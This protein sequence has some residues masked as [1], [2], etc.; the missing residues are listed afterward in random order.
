M[1]LELLCSGWC[2]W[3]VTILRQER[4][5][6]WWGSSGLQANLFVL[7]PLHQIPFY[8]GAAFKAVVM[9]TDLEA[10]WS[11]V[12]VYGTRELQG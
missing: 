8:Y 10:R 11:V 2:R 9:D 12:W 4:K 3:Q 1:S 5:R 6:K 7:L